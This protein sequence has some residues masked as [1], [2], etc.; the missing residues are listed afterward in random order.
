MSIFLRSMSS[1]ASLT[2][3][4][5]LVNHSVAGL[6]QRYLQS[7]GDGMVHETKKTVNDADD[8]MDR[9]KID[10]DVDD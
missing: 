5:G 6:L 3:F 4:L 10:I 1:S 7:S 2:V 8:D 9:K